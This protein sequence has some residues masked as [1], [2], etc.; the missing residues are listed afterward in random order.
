MNN[1]IKVVLILSLLNINIIPFMSLGTKA[2]ATSVVQTCT[3]SGETQFFPVGDERDHSLFIQMEIVRDCNISMTVQGPCIKWEDKVE[4]Y[5]LD[6]SD[7][8]TYRSKNNEDSLA[9]MLATLGAYDQIG[10]LWSG[11][12]GYCEIGTKTNFDWASDPM[13]WASLALST[14]MEG[15]QQG[16]FLDGTIVDFVGVEAAAG[17]A[18][19]GLGETIGMQLS[20]NFGKCLV[21]AGVDIA[22]STYNYFAEEDDVACDPID[23]FCGGEDEQTE[24][25]DILTIDSVQYEDIITK[26][27]EAVD[28]ITVLGE[29]NGI[30]TVRFKMPNEMEGFDEA[31]EEEMEEMLQKMKDIQFLI[32]SAFTAAKMATCAATT[33]SIGGSSNYGNQQSDR[34]SVKDGIGMALNALPANLLGPYGALI[35]AALVVALEFFSSFK[36]INTCFNEEDAQEAGSRHQKTQQTLPYDLCQPTREVCA[37]REFWG[38]GC[39]LDGYFYCC[40]DQLLTKILVGQIKAQLGRDWAHCTGITLKD[41]GAVSFRQCTAADKTSG[42]DGTKVVSMYNVDGDLQNPADW[43]GSF[44]YKKK[45]IDLE[46]FKE[47]LEATFSQ[48]IDFGDFDMIFNDMSDQIEP[49]PQ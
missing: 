8:N 44:Q 32:S 20:E 12:K 15:S 22:S 2:N 13:F 34:F 28:Y 42:F 47:H 21:A 9:E 35:K 40:Y 3:V 26:F 41:L 17:S 5:F 19:K 30:M 36:D 39:G 31:A 6:P 33:G 4:N 43:S 14:V 45:C 24:E 16:G 38:S 46:E 7:Y 48:D 23:E 37:Q 10:H 25:S 27:P 49:I 29:E 11:W 1:I 18:W